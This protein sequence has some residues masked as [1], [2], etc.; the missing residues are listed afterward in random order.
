MKVTN[1]AT[2]MACSSD[3]EKF[4][5]AERLGR[6]AAKQ[7]A[8]V[9]LLQEMF[10]THFFAFTDWKAEYFKSALWQNQLYSIELSSRPS[11]RLVLIH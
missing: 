10:A 9:I 2:Q 8:N 3:M 11:A 5:T 1:A 4:D 6:N 7:G